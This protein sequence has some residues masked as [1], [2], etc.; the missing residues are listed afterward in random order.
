[1]NGF[2]SLFTRCMDLFLAVRSDETVVPAPLAFDK[3]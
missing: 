2:W 3:Q 1:M